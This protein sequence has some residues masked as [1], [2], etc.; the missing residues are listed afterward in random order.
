VHPDPVFGNSSDA[1]CDTIPAAFTTFAAHSSPLG[2]VLFP[3]TDT[4]LK[5]TFLVALHGAGHHASA[6]VITSSASRRTTARRRTSLPAFT[7]APK[8]PAS[9]ATSASS[10]A[11]AGSTAPAPTA[12]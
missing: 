2:V 10:G 4:L 7:G 9:P 1:H 3:R 11:P 12:S 5:N 8:F 6:P